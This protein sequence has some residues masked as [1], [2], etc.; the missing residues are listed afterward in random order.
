M[1]G[2]RKSELLS[3]RWEMIDFELG[4]LKLPKTTTKTAKIDRVALPAVAMS[5]LESLPS[6]GESAWLFPS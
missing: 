6:R 3:A 1:L 5:L 4:V 2:K